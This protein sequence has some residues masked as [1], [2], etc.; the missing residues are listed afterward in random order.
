[1]VRSTFTVVTRDTSGRGLRSAGAAGGLRRPGHPGGPDPGLP[2][3]DHGGGRAGRRHRPVRD[4]RPVGRGAG[5]GLG[6]RSVAAGGAG[7]HARDSGAVP[8]HDGRAADAGGAGAGPTARARSGAVRLHRRLAGQHGLA[9]PAG[10]QPDQPARVRAAAARRGGVHAADVGTGPGGLGGDGRAAGGGVPTTTARPLRGAEAVPG[11]GSGA[12]HRRRRR[13][14]RTRSGVRARGGRH[15]G[16]G[17]RC[18]GAGRRLPRATPAPGGLAAASLAPGARCQC[19][20]RPGG[21]RARVRP[22]HPGDRA[23]RPGGRMGAICCAWPGCPPWPP[24]C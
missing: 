10:V 3:G 11:R 5:A 1:M 17:D 19:P 15:G 6:A 22:H 16:R 2:G 14:R 9:D 23:G 7:R 12:A 4:H 13:L 21:D 24:T 20:V 18:P 8:G